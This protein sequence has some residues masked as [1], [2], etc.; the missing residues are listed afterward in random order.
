MTRPKFKHLLRG[1]TSLRSTVASSLRICLPVACATQR[2]DAAPRQLFGYTPTLVVATLALLC[3]THTPVTLAATIAAIKGDSFVV[4][5]ECVNGIV[6]NTPEYLPVGAE[7]TLYGGLGGMTKL[8]RSGSAKWSNEDKIRFWDP[9]GNN[10]PY[11][12][13]Q[14]INNDQQSGNYD[15]AE[16]RGVKN[17]PPTQGVYEM[18][19]ISGSL[20]T[21]LGR[22]YTVT[23]NGEY[24][25]TYS[26]VGNDPTPE[27]QTPDAPTITDLVPGNQLLTA[28]YIAGQEHTY[29]IAKYQYKL[30]VVG[31]SAGTWTDITGDKP[32]LQQAATLELPSLVNGTT[33]AVTVRAI[34]SQGG[35][36]DPSNTVTDTPRIVC[37]DEDFPAVGSGAAANFECTHNDVTYEFSDFHI[38]TLTSSA[39]QCASLPHETDRTALFC[40]QDGTS[41]IAAFDWWNQ[42]KA[43]L[44]WLE[45]VQQVGSRRVEKGGRPALQYPRLYREDAVTSSTW[46]NLRSP[47]WPVWAVPVFKVWIPVMSAWR[48]IC[49]MAPLILTSR[50]ILQPGTYRITFI[51]QRCSEM[52]RALTRTLVGLTTAT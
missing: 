48:G 14:T 52:R 31:G 30:D 43:Q 19:Y 4:G 5:N 41:L 9:K 24:P 46:V 21:V 51:P 26:C 2:I 20:V 10:T 35:E 18:R 7:Q 29:P 39:N 37:S 25:I 34:D 50:L 8:K 42:S 12:T 17:P 47:E 44:S 13:D 28:T 6:S 27:D 23:S 38:L 11:G 1:V 32:T 40:K 45:E 16:F 22:L 36:G 33:Y 3:I 49:S 15:E